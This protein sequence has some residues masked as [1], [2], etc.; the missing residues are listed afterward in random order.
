MKQIPQLPSYL[1][2]LSEE[3]LKPRG[4]HLGR[5]YYPADAPNS[6]IGVARLVALL[7]LKEDT[8]ALVSFYLN[9]AEHIHRIVHVPT[10]EQEYVNFWLQ[11]PQLRHPAMAA[12]ILSMISIAIA[13]SNLFPDNSPYR[14]MAPHWISASARWLSGEWRSQPSR[15]RNLVYYQ[16]SCLVYLAKRV[17][18]VRQN[19]FWT[20]T[21]RLI[22]TAIMDGLHLDPPGS[23]TP[24]MREMKRRIWATLREL[25]L[26]TSFDYGLPTVLHTLDSTISAPSNINDSEF[27]PASTTIP[28]SRPPR[29]YTQTSYQSSSA[30][31]FDLRVEIS[32]QLFAGGRGRTNPQTPYTQV[33]QYTHQLT[34]ALD[35][36]PGWTIEAGVP[37]DADCGGPRKVTLMV[38]ALLQYQLK[39]CLILLHRQFV[40][41]ILISPPTSVESPST[42]RYYSQSFPSSENS[43]S[44]LSETILYQNA[45]SILVLTRKLA[46]LG[47]QCLIS[48][49]NDLTLACLALC[50]VTLSRPKGS[51]SIP[52]INSNQ[53]VGLLEDML[54]FFE[55]SFLRSSHIHPLPFVHPGLSHTSV[56]DGADVVGSL[57]SNN[58]GAAGP[59]TLQSRIA[60]GLPTTNTPAAWRTLMIYAVLVVTKIH[61][62]KDDEARAHPCCANRFSRFWSSHIDRQVEH[63]Y[64]HNQQQHH[65]NGMMTM[66]GGG[67]DTGYEV[68]STNMWQHTNTSTRSYSHDG[69]LREGPQ[70]PTM[71]EYDTGTS[72]G[73]NFEVSSYLAA[74]LPYYPFR[75]G[76]N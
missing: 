49:R 21:A 70:S 43:S 67:D 29:N 40:H 38:W 64:Q 68:G 71:N 17:N 9:H 56:G 32:K 44:S 24:Y 45:L 65:Q 12:L 22:Q 23:D 55:A 66:I 53:T 41:P 19:P 72:N 31:S 59:G 61:V 47:S 52:I 16:I 48:M 13:T 30:R 35:S 57:N 25:D 33:L 73:W 75:E 18:W 6:N 37:N 4:I 36:L 50:L 39:E 8:D 46:V 54:P 69:H 28:A 60:A 74:D 11:E 3:H 5:T 20:D 2:I 27:S 14:P 26:Q 7:P 42:S 51:L 1:Q 62:G 15:P 63:Q 76:G 10:F 58:T 34:Q